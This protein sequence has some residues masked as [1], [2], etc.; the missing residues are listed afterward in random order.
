[1]IRTVDK[2]ADLDVAKHEASRAYWNEVVTRAAL[3]NE[4]V[5]CYWETGGDINRTTGTAI[6]TYAI[7]GIMRA[8]N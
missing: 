1:M 7:D 4:C 2:Y 6:N 8:K 3:H 5:P